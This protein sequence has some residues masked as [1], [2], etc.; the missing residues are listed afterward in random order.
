MVIKANGSDA[1]AEL[2]GAGDQEGMV[3]DWLGEARVVFILFSE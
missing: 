3:A 2:E 1:E